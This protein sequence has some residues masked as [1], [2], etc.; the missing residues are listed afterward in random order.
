MRVSTVLYIMSASNTTLRRL[1]QTTRHVQGHVPVERGKLSIVQGCSEPALV[2]L[3]LGELLDEQCEIRGNKEC[4]VVPWTGAR[5]TYS[6]LQ[7]R[8]KNLAKAM[9]ALGVRGG[10]RVGILASNCEEYVAVFFAAGYIGCVLVVLNSTYTAVE[11][12]Y[13]LHHS[14]K[15]LEYKSS[16]SFV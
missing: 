7:E 14:G 13:A 3:S 1:Q 5:W 9:L 10:D 6:D 12:Q 15:L 4:L 8:S 11:A 2:D 16:G